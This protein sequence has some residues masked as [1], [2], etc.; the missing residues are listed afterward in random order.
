M[1]SMLII[2]KHVRSLLCGWFK[3]VPLSVM[4]NENALV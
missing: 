1:E 3:A 2:V 4:L